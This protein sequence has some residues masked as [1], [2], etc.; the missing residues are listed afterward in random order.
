MYTIMIAFVVAMLSVLTGSAFAQESSMNEAKLHA[1]AADNDVAA[2]R[3]LLSKGTKVD[4]KDQ[5]GR[6][7]LLIATHGNKV[8]A[9]RALIEAGANV[10]AKDNINDSPY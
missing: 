2:I 5:E 6:T 9:A 3:D 10:N 7:A 4:A 8:D 1:A